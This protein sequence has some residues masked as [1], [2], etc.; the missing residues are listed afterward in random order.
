MRCRW[1]ELLGLAVGLFWT[2]PASAQQIRELGLVAV[3]TSSNPALAVAGVYGA[4]RTIGRTRVSASLGLGISDGELAWRGE[5]LGHFLLS[6]EERHKAGLY[7]AGG[8]AAVGGPVSRGYLVVTLGVEG[9]PRARS[10]WAVEAGFGGGL[11]VAL[12]YRWRWFLG[13]P[14]Q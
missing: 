9:K 14:F 11:R 10:G 7:F 6:P 8:V 3:A 5:L 12:G 1:H 13:V 2:V 4:F